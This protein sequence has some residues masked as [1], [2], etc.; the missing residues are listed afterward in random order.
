M[1]IAV[2]NCQTP[3]VTGGA[4][5]H[6]ANLIKELKARGHEADLVTLPFKWYPADCLSDAILAAQALDISQS[7][8]NIIDLAIGLKFPAYLMRHPQKV[9][10]ILHQHREAYELFDDNIGSLAAE[11]DGWAVREAIRSIDTHHLGGFARLFANS[12]TVAARLK[13]NNGL[14]A[15]ALYHPPPLASELK[16][17]SL[18]DYFYIP[19]RIS[20]LKRQVLVL[21]AL[22]MTRNPVK[23]VFS[24][25]FEDPTSK[26]AF[27]TSLQDRRIE[28]RVTYAGRVSIEEMITLYA[29]ALGVVFAPIDEDYGYITLEAMCAGKAVVTATDSGGPLE[30][31]REGVEGKVVEPRVETLAEALDLLWE[32]RSLAASLGKAGRERYHGLGISWD[33]A[34]RALLG[35]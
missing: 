16:D 3:F 6:A 13:R 24:G 35:S 4:E 9:G 26:A 23:A 1:R 31:I 25:A 15:T 20:G 22:A 7:S 32:N 30:F 14:E 11:P 2:L 27:E 17:G 19:S 28:G 34:I 29:G 8:G 18:G 5:L 12:Q 21:E 33:H 10:W